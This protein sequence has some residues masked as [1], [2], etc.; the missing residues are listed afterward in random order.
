MAIFAGSV[1]VLPVIGVRLSVLEKRMVANLPAA[2]GAALFPPTADQGTAAL[3]RTVTP[4][5]SQSTWPFARDVLRLSS[6]HKG[7]RLAS[8]LH[9]REMGAGTAI[10][11]ACLFCPALE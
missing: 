5:L 11:L 1:D 4:M 6:G 3:S 8:A 9:V 7:I 10:G 2:D